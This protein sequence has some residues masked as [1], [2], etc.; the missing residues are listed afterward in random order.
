MTLF[1]AILAPVIG[2][3]GLFVGAFV[4]EWLRRKNR[5]EQ[6]AQTVFEKRLKVYE[7]LIE[8]ISEGEKIVN[9]FLEA[10]LSADER[11]DLVS[12]AI[13]GV[14]TYVDQNT[15]YLDEEI[16]MHCVALFMGTEEIP[17][18]TDDN[19]KEMTA[20]YH[21]MRK[22]AYQMIREDSGVA[23]LDRLF[24]AVNRPLIDSPVIE[25]YRERKKEQGQ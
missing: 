2:F 11:H 14:A 21:Q 7:E 19:R 23:E 8:K 20:N 17:D 6:F 10:H 5:R 15:L 4:N 3:V 1:L 18:A 25:Y 16:G 24:K 22:A 9:S 13:H 12:I